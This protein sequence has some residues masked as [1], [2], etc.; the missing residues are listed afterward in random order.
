MLPQPHFTLILTSQH[1]TSDKKAEKRTWQLL[2]QLNMDNKSHI[3]FYFDLHYEEWL[4]VNG[5][6]R[7]TNN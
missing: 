7:T 3:W 5:K 1:W 2:F 4:H 6:K